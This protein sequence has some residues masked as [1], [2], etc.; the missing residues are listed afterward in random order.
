MKIL[1]AFALDKVV[2]L[3]ENQVCAGVIRGYKLTWFGTIT[4]FSYLVEFEYV[5]R[6]YKCISSSN[7]LIHSEDIYLSVDELIEKIKNFRVDEELKRKT[8]WETLKTET[9]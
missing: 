7:E 6:E 1:Y 3:C 9:P 4:D 5:N 2:V 8:E